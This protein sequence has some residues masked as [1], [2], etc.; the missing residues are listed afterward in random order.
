MHVA[1]CD[2]VL[3]SAQYPVVVFISS[4]SGVVQLPFTVTVLVADVDCPAE[5]VQVY[6]T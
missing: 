1:P 5:S 2:R 6:V 3:P 4:T